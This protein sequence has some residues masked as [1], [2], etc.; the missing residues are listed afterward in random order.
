MKSYTFLGIAQISAELIQAGWGTL[1][2]E[3]RELVNEMRDCEVR[4]YVNGPASCRG[5]SM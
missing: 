5:V 4:I 2:S 3:I 1:R